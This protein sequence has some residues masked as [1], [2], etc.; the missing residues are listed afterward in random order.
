LLPE[1]AADLPAIALEAEEPLVSLKW[2]KLR[3]R[4]EDPAFARANL[5]AGLAAGAVLEIDLVA[6]ADG[7]LV[8]LHDLTLDRETTGGGPVSAQPSAAVLALRQ[9]DSTGRPTESG[10]LSLGEIV[11]LL[12]ANPPADRPDGRVQLD[13]KEPPAGITLGVCRRF[14]AALGDLGGWFT[15]SG[16][17]WPAVERI[18]AAVPGLA[19]GFDPEDAIEA[20]MPLHEVP[21]YL[22]ET[23]PSARIFYLEHGFVLECLAT[24]QNPIAPL[25]A[26][27]K[28]VDCWTLDADHDRV[29]GKLEALIAAGANQITTNDPERLS[30]LWRGRPGR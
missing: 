16:P 22:L 14:A 13:L 5:K 17:S 7:D 20:G 6:T 1:L 21:R 3:R 18:A 2:H 11:E 30:Q 29:L 25:R 19:T 28:R 4:R 8:C 26:A 12:R 15:L 24:R 23:A 10:V 9:R 27:G